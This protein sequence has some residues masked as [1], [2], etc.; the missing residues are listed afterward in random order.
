MPDV[1]A[2]V[3]APGGADDLAGACVRYLDML[4]HVRRLSPRTLVNYERDLGDLRRRAQLAGAGLGGIG[5]QHIRA[6]VAALHGGG[7]TP[8]AIAA[9]LSAWR[10][11]FSWLGLQGLVASNPL[12]DV[13]APRAARPLPKAISVDQAVAL[14]A[15][16]PQDHAPASADRRTQQTQALSL[17]RGRAIAELLYSSG[18]RVS[19]L[20]SLDTRYTR[21]PGHESAGWVDWDAAEV[22]VLGK[23]GK[24]RSVPVGTPAMQ[25]LRDWLALRPASSGDGGDQAALFLGPR[26]RRITTQRVWVELRERARAAGLPTA[27][28]PHMLRHSFASHLLQSSGDLRGVQELLGHASIASTQIYIRLDFQHLAKVYDA[29]HPRAKKR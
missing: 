7:M 4:R 9:R 17:A 20:T 6:W 15:Y 13:R 3:P 26:G 11:L 19:E 10:G 24:R 28:H 5:P 25:A 14:A 22:T 27:V 29:A 12:Q 21:A 2:Q 18:L 23:G 8:R 1:P 16:A